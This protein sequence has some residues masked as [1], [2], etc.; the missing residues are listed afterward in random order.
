M[1]RLSR[2]WCSSRCSDSAPVRPPL[3]DAIREWLAGDAMACTSVHV[4]ES[5]EET[6]LLE[7]GDG[8]FRDLLQ[9]L[10][11]WD[12]Q[13]TPPGCGPVEYLERLQFLGPRTLAVHGVQ[14]DSAD[15]ARL[16]R[17][18]A[19]LVTCPRSNRYVGVGDPPV[20]R[21]YQSTVP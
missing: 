4:A 18:G 20:A 13:W 7:H 8:S 12:A 3:F 1:R 14:M 11:A 17:A 10:G 2:L 9:E 21:F 15:L 6:E 5:P 19:T 16:A